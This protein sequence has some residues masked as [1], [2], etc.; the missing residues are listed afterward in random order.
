VSNISNKVIHSKG[1]I[2][3]EVMEHC[4]ED[5]QCTP[6]PNRLHVSGTGITLSGYADMGKAMAKPC[7]L[8]LCAVLGSLGIK[9][10]E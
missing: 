1:D 6:T 2:I 4:D 5:R 9:L 10:S 7:Q 8:Q 3:T